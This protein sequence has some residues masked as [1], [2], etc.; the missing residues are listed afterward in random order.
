NQGTIFG[1]LGPNGAGL[2]KPTEGDATFNG[3]S[4][5]VSINDIYRSIGVYPRRDIL[6]DNLTGISINH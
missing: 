1:L 3:L 6:W 4:I 5:S 2:Y